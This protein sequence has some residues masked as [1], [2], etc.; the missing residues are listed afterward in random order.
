MD[1]LTGVIRVANRNM[2]KLGFI[3]GPHGYTWALQELQKGSCQPAIG[4]VI[5]RFVLL[6]AALLEPEIC[7]HALYIF[8]L[9]VA[10]YLP[11]SEAVLG[12]FVWEP[13]N[14]KVNHC[15]SF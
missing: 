7:Y 8:L 6:H 1:E 3:C 5:C 15:L 13:C 4:Q 11:D 2:D 14:S 10:T 12:M 9:V